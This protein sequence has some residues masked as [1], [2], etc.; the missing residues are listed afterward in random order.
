ML[1]TKEEV[2]AHA[3]QLEILDP[4]S[5]FVRKW[6]PVVKQRARELGIPLEIKP[7]REYIRQQL[8]QTR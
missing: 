6:T 7:D 2:F 5:S 8:P 1:D 4:R 3:S